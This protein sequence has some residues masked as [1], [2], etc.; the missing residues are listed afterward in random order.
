MQS[1]NHSE[2]LEARLVEIDQQVA[3]L[4]AAEIDATWVAETLADFDRIWELLTMENRRRLIEALVSMV[5]VDTEAELIT[6]ELV[7]IG[8]DSELRRAS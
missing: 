3:A 5:A 7:D 2:H 4:D 8:P 6:V 1:N